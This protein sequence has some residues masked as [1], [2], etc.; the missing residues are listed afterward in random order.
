[1]S[2]LCM[3]METNGIT[4]SNNFSHWFSHHG[5]FSG[6]KSHLLVLQSLY[7]KHFVVVVQIQ[8]IYI[9][10]ALITKY[11]LSLKLASMFCI[12]ANCSLQ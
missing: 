4:T 6:A 1:M 7:M 12:I 11:Q 3:W 2:Y 8:T 9:T 10:A 5:N